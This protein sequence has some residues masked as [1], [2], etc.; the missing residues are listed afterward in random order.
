MWT[1]FLVFWLG[2]LVTGLAASGYGIFELVVAY[3]EPKSKEKEESQVEEIA[4]PVEEVPVAKPVEDEEFE[5][6]I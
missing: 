2:I 5:V 6:E 3:R 4:E 1:A